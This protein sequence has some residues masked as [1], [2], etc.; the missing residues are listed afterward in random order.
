MKIRFIKD[1]VYESGPKEKWPRYKAGEIYDLE[2][3]HARRWLRREV[4]VVAEVPA[5]TDQAQSLEVTDAEVS[6][7]VADANTADINTSTDIST[8]DGEGEG[9]PAPRSRK[10]KR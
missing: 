6:G 4:A 5:A 9:D 10:A 2:E 1:A 3:D 7:E 8:S